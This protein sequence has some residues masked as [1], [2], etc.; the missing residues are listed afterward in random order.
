VRRLL[1]LDR[2]EHL[3]GVVSL[4]DVATITGDARLTGGVLE[5]VSEPSEPPP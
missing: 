2:D 5:G 1:I 4:G 3:V